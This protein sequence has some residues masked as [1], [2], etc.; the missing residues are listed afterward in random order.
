LNQESRHAHPAQALHAAVSRLR[1]EEGLSTRQRR[2]PIFPDLR[3]LRPHTH[4]DAPPEQSGTGRGDSPSS[5]REP[6]MKNLLAVIGLY[7]VL[8]KGWELYERY[9]AMHEENESLRK[10]KVEIDM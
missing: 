2:A 6:V 8:R 7:V 5:F 10:R 3:A 4:Q 9:E 1:L